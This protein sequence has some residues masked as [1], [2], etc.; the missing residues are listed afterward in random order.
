[1]MDE[2]PLPTLPPG[3]IDPASMA[4]DGATK[5]ANDVL[6][7]FNAAL[8]A[9]DAATLE[10][11]FYSSQA[12][13]KDQLALTYHLRTFETPNVVAASL[14]ETKISERNYEGGRGR[15]R[16]PVHSSRS[17][18]GEFYPWVCVKEINLSNVTVLT[19]RARS[20]VCGSGI[21]GWT[22]SGSWVGLPRSIGGS[23][24]CWRFRLRLR[25]REFCRRRIGI[26]LCRAE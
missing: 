11:C 21:C 8:A 12:Y 3:L 16:G 2:Q 20:V 19:K 6:I 1:M 23:R 9:D 22:T 18:S 7:R 10:S 17:C 4:G 15:W 26:H 13:W 5:Q 25:R 14:L 24:E